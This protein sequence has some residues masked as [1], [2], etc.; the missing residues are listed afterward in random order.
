MKLDRLFLAL[1][2]SVGQSTYLRGCLSIVIM[3]VS[4][5]FETNNFRVMLDGTKWLSKQFCFVD[6]CLERPTMNN[7]VFKPVPERHIPVVK[8]F[9]GRQLEVAGRKTVHNGPSACVLLYYTC[10]AG[11]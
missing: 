2:T 6:H 10:Q 5:H 8:R 9:R 7:P 11:R 3:Q 4:M 1:P